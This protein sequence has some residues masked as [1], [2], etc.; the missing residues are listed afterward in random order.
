MPRDVSIVLGP[1][2]SRLRPIAYSQLQA[3]AA[4]R[5]DVELR[6]AETGTTAKRDTVLI[7][8]T[9]QIPGELLFVDGRLQIRDPEH[10]TLDWMIELATELG[11]RVRDNTL[12]T[13][14]TAVDTYRHPDDDASRLQL[15]D[16]IRKAR[17]IDRSPPRSTLHAFIWWAAIAAVLAVALVRLLNRG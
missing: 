15:A 16:A 6:Q 13:Y 2:P 9:G 14:R 12:K 11:G 8:P 5:P 3:L 17:K 4:R 1:G 7:D 10:V